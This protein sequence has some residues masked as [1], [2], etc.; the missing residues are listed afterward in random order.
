M[1]RLLLILSLVCFAVLGRAEQITREQAL[2]QAQQFLSQRGLTSSLKMAETPLSR[3][4]AQGQ[5]QPDYYYVFNAGQ[6]QGFVI[7]SGDD[8]AE[9]ILGYATSGSFD[10]D[11]IPSNMVAW[12]QD[13]ADQ[14]KWIQD[15]NIQPRKPYAIRRAF[16]SV[17]PIVTS[18]WNQFEP[19]NNEC[20]TDG[21]EKCVTGCVTTA[22]SQILY[23]YSKNGFKPTSTAIPGY[24]TADGKFTLPDLPATS[25]DWDNM[26]DQYGGSATQAQNDAVAKLFQYVGTGLKAEYNTAKNGGTLVWDN[27]PEIVFKNYFGYGSGIELIRRMDA[28]PESEWDNLIYNEIANGRPVLYSGQGSGGGHTFIVHGYDGAGKYLINWGWGGYQDAYFALSAL[29]PDGGGAGAGASGYNYDQT[30]LVGISPDNVNPYTITVEETPVLSA[31]GI[32]VA[33]PS[34]KLNTE[35]LNPADYTE[36]T[37]DRDAN[38]NV[39]FAL[40]FDYG[41]NLY[42]NYTFNVGFGLFKDGV[43]Q[44]GYQNFGN[45]TIGGGNF[46]FYFSGSMGFG[47]GLSNGDYQLKLA[48][49]LASASEWSLCV[50]ADSHILNIRVTDTTITF[51]VGDL[52][53]PDPT[54]EV[55]QTELDD[56]TA[57]YAAKKLEIQ[58]K[59]NEIANDEERLS[60]IQKAL[61]KKKNALNTIDAQISALE[62][63]LNNE[64]LTAEQKQSYKDQLAAVKSQSA[65]LMA[66]YKDAEKK[67]LTCYEATASL[68][69][70]LSNLLS[71]LNTEAAAVSSITT[72]AELE[73]S[74]AKLSEIDTQL[75]GCAVYKVTDEITVLEDIITTIDKTSTSDMETSLASIESTIDAA[76]EA[77]KQTEQEEKD[78]EAKE[79]LEAA[80]KELLEKYTNMEKIWSD[81]EKVVT[82]YQHDYKKLDSLSNE[83]R[84]AIEDVEK[85]IASIKESL[86]NDMLSA[87]V[88]S[89]LES[90]LA[91]LEKE[92][93]ACEEALESLLNNPMQK[94]QS[95][96]DD[97]LTELRNVYQLIVENKTA[98]DALTLTSNLEAALRESEDVEKR[99]AAIDV[100][101]E[102]QELLQQLNVS[103]HDIQL[104][105]I[106]KALETLEDDV[107]KAIAGGQEEY[108]KM[109]AEKLAKAQEE[110]A[111]A[112][113]ALEA[114]IKSE[115]ADYEKC[116]AVVNNLKAKL[117]EINASI[118][119]FKD[120]YAEI[121]KNLQALIDKQTRADNSEIIEGLQKELAELKDNIE[122]LESQSAKVA[123]YI[124]TL[125]Q[126]AKSY[127]TL[128]E[129]A[130]AA[131]QELQNSLSSATTADEVDK[132][133]TSA[134]K[135]KSD[136]A[137]EG[138]DW[139]NLLVENSNTVAT[140]VEGVID[141]V[142]V[143]DR[144]TTRLD[145]EVQ[146]TLTGISQVVIDESEVAARYDVKG[147]RVDST[148]K[149]VQIVRMKNGKTIKINVK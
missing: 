12:L 14:I 103:L 101:A 88:K 57:Q 7:V 145:K 78:K 11:R 13:Y 62:E 140:Y 141:N 67:F 63:K 95:V 36:Y 31:V 37:G 38:G 58:A 42:N 128:I 52:S 137:S 61:S 135:T 129:E 46:S 55:S 107:D 104:D 105:N 81:K 98:V 123:G 136:L 18:E 130:K 65:T 24:S 86:N 5:I 59:I 25:F 90:R 109:Q 117:A 64:Y 15:H 1:K 72:K 21:S 118:A 106:V 146:E 85:K 77:G 108:E 39:G 114:A 56:L 68:K 53:T 112:I 54:S 113:D 97:L 66:S 17:A 9:A 8:R 26:I 70:T 45:I 93:K 91:A 100:T 71:S 126:Q 51:K 49:K 139:Y 122:I 142:N 132:L 41:V 127:A 134:T 148:Y 22:V 147:N 33:D 131:K 120:K 30:A 125:E 110:F 102:M 40:K 34:V 3:H 29:D 116:L 35:G 23:H 44:G 119:Q 28:I 111:A 69:T 133:T 89:D 82:D 149:G 87:D 20:P 79:K 16:A 19:Y 32:M 138:V 10:V 124:E 43:L 92:K 60:N 143:V 83:I 80:Q 4:R 96:I 6:N 2:R 99:L 144:Q 27:M 76:I 121:E 94:V 74:T 73:A 75:S 50:D 48:Y 115:E 47:Q 84:I